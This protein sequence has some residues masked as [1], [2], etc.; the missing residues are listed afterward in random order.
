[1]ETFVLI[2]H[3]LTAVSIVVLV[4][5]QQ[6]KGA[7]MGAAFGSGASGSLF[8]A[9]GSTNFLSRSTAIAA[10]VFFITSLVLT[11]FTGRDHVSGGVMQSGAAAQAQMAVKPMPLVPP[12]TAKPQQPVSGQGDTNSLRSKAGEIPR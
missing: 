9:S 3:L 12:V 10:T 8:G 5:L 4:L 1:M 11:W 2:I 7:D 6:G